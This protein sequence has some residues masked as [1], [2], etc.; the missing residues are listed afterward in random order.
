MKPMKS[1]N[2]H[3]GNSVESKKYREFIMIL[4]SGANQPEFHFRAI[5]TYS[6]LTISYSFIIIFEHGLNCRRW[7]PSVDDS[8]HSCQGSRRNCDS[9]CRIFRVI[10]S[11]PLQ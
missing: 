8:A 3:T 11:F 6:D 4:S 1:F 7:T 10:G 5:L 9:D 2:V